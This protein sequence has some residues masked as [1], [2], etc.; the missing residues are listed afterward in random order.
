[1]MKE[2]RMDVFVARQPIFDRKLNVFGYELLYRKSMN[3]FYEG[4]DD[5]QATAELINHALFLFAFVN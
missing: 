3:N 1:M 4:T 2:I 5:N